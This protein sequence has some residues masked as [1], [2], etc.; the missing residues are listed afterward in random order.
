M[1][2]SSLSV[3]VLPVMIE[4]PA[5]LMGQVMYVIVRQGSQER[6]VRIPLAGKG[7]VRT[8]GSVTWEAV[9]VSWAIQVTYV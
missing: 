9:Y 7:P 5:W 2:Q 8:V 3:W 4:A 6:T 1:T